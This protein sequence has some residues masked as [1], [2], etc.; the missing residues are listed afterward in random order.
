MQNNFC[1]K[2]NIVFILNQKF[3]CVIIAETH[4]LFLNLFY[5]PKSDSVDD[6]IDIYDSGDV[7]LPVSM[8]HDL[9]R[10]FD[11]ESF[12]RREVTYLPDEGWLQ[13]NVSSS[14]SSFSNLYNCF[15]SYHPADESWERSDVSMLLPPVS[16]A[17]SIEDR[18][19][20]D[21]E[22]VSDQLLQRSNLDPYPS[23]IGVDKSFALDPEFSFL[24]GLCTPSFP[25]S[26]L[27]LEDFKHCNVVPRRPSL[28]SVS[29]YS[30]SSS[31]LPCSDPTTSN[32]EPTITRSSS[33][34]SASKNHAIDHSVLPDIGCDVEEMKQ[35]SSRKNQLNQLDA[36]LQESCAKKLEMLQL[37][38]VESN[39]VENLP[40]IS[41][42][43]NSDHSILPP[44]DSQ[45]EPSPY[46][47]SSD[48]LLKPRLGRE[49]ST[50][51]EDANSRSEQVFHIV[52][53]SALALSVAVRCHVSNA[54]A[55]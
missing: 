2:G 13:T 12:S 3:F 7:F 44:I 55:F 47:P 48:S 10:D 20:D 35:S 27:P 1:N 25:L 38:Q 42:Q 14:S 52:A 29:E 49:L 5:L 53:C 46:C 39:V 16:L 22:Q 43:W 40:S 33:S 37:H 21:Y 34:S 51:W 19:F 28:S 26:S 17:H 9:N 8:W 24:H 54:L 30:E 4:V 36:D 18:D 45:Q 41:R 32:N 50:I 31:P 6:K 11:G 15:P 23:I